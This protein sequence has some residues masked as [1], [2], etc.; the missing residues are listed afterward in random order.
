MSIEYLFRIDGAEDNAQFFD[1]MR[2]STRHVY[3]GAEFR[4]G[5]FGWKPDFVKIV[6][7]EPPGACS[8]TLI[9]L[10]ATRA[11]ALISCRKYLPENP[12]KILNAFREYLDRVIR[13]CEKKTDPRKS[14]FIDVKRILSDAN[15]IT[16]K[17][18]GALRSSTTFIEEL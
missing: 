4:V 2:A 16:V 1:A 3:S 11:A 18:A 13:E 10:E 17:T 14:E 7:E 12:V 6:V 15:P 8:L 5:E 9:E